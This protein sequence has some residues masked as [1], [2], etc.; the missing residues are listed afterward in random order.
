[1]ASTDTRPRAAR[2]FAVV[3]GLLMVAAIAATAWVGSRAL[4]AE[5]YLQ[6]ARS[7][8]ASLDS[9]VLVDPLAASEVLAELRDNTRS[10]RQ[11]TSDPVWFLA[12]RLPWAGP[13]LHAVSATAT[14]LDETVAAL[15]PLVEKVAEVGVTSLTPSNGAVDI[16]AFETIEPAASS[17]ATRTRQAAQVLGSLAGAPLPARV[18]AAVDEASAL[19][20]SVAET[21]DGL[22]RATRLLPLVLGAE[23][24]RDYLVLF[25][26]N[27]EWRSL[28]GLVGSVA[29][30]HTESGAYS[31]TGQGSGGG[32]GAREESPLVLDDEVLSIYD[33]RPGRFPGNVTQLPDFA[34]AAPLA[35]EYWRLKYGQE[36]DGVVAIDPVALSYLLAVTGPILLPTG[37]RLTSDNLVPLLLNEVYQRYDDPLLQDEFF[38]VASAAVFQAVASRPLDLRALLAALGRAA[39]ENRLFI[40]SAQTDEQAI[41]DGTTLQGSLPVTDSS[42][43]RFG[44]Y[45]NDGTGSKMDYYMRLQTSAAWCGVTT[46]GA[47]EAVLRVRVRND[48][49]P[50][51]AD[52]TWFITGGGLNGVPP[53]VARTVAYVYLPAGSTSLETSTSEG[54]TL[55]GDTHQ[56]RPVLTWTTDLPP[57]ASATLD[58]SVG[59]PLTPEL[60]IVKTATLAP[61]SDVSDSLC[62]AR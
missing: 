10:A 38:E 58:V 31:L 37:D 27:A 53:G 22:A 39:D 14:S 44:V 36:A 15:A 1:M 50:D 18:Q 61:S 32:L 12:E 35:R 21:T 47:R 40:W 52:L 29:L 24:P 20:S 9:D 4:L 62:A 17:A 25:Q 30:L 57:G 11:L 16:G 2:I 45:V 23:G 41:L 3:L 34:L 33:N 55:R 7:L 46:D 56:G 5:R 6:D 19:A 48:A 8:A 60:E 43:T 54:S 28:G 51:A 42:T 59:A 49:P 26:N 13:L